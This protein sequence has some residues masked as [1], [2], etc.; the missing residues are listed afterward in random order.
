VPNDTPDLLDGPVQILSHLVVRKPQHGVATQ[1]ELE[2]PL[3]V[4]RECR[5]VCVVRIAVNFYN[6][7][8]DS[9]Q[10]VNAWT[11]AMHRLN[12]LIEAEEAREFSVFAQ[13][14]CEALFFTAQR[15]RSP[16]DRTHP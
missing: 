11:S 12:E 3:T 13:G 8:T 2:V 6:E 9:P 10:H 16:T 5:P 1:Q 7:A 14:F 15:M 4:P